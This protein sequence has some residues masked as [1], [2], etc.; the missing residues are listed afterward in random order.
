M[1][2]YFN[3]GKT[4]FEEAVNS[5]IFVDKTEMI[6]YLNSVIKT[7]QKYVCVSRPRRFGKS[8]AAKMLCAYYDREADSR[9]LFEKCKI[10]KSAGEESA[11]EWD[12]YL[13]EF[14]VIRLVMTEFMQDS[15]S[16]DDMLD[17]LSEEVI[18]ELK[19]IYP[20]V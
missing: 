7:E 16:I 9:S 11:P 12:K 4:A 20:G 6:R 3:P 8:M 1:G 17:Y 10:S 19:E 15:V 18:S 5:E 2:I 14:D 13:G